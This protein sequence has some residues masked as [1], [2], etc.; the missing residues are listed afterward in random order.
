MPARPL[1]HRCH[2]YK[3]L[4][5]QWRALAKRAGLR[6][7]EFAKAGPWPVFYLESRVKKGTED[8]AW[9]YISAGVHGDEAAPPWGLLEWAEDNISLLQSHP[10]ILFPV[11]NPVGLMLNTRTDQRGVDLNRAFN[12][13]EDPLIAAWNQVVG[14]RRFAIAVCLHEDYDGQGCYVYEL[15]RRRESIGTKILK[16]TS[17]IVATDER[18]RIDGRGAKKGLIIRR[19]PPDMP[20]LPEAIVLHNLGSPVT[21]T[22]ESP[23]EFCLTDRTAVQKR[24][25]GSSLKHGA[26]LA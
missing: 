1:Q 15:T 26:G 5:Q 23:S 6:M 7:K 8:L 4:V 17:R 14:Q 10:F 19:I 12:S 16:D 24:F 21:L 2:D 9:H 18:K 22:F 13:T 11:L 25:I 20:G 3:L